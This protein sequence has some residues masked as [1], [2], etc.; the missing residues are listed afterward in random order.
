MHKRTGTIYLENG[1]LT[2]DHT[3]NAPGIPWVIEWG[4]TSPVSDSDGWKHRVWT[5]TIGGVTKQ[6]RTGLAVGISRQ[7]TGLMGG[8][9]G[10]V[11]DR[12]GHPS[13]PYVHIP[14]IF[15]VLG[16]WVSD[17]QCVEFYGLDEFASEFGFTAPSKAIA[18]FQA[19]HDTARDLARIFGA[20]LPQWQQALEAEGY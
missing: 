4:S 16:S 17:A 5:I 3:E 9:V 19:C 11:L 20:D 7:P 13:G 1:T 8:C 6:Y 2:V 12:F 18:A 10:R 15:A 14:D